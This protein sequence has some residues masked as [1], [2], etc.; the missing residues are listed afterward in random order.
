MKALTK[1]SSTKLDFNE[2]TKI[3]LKD[4]DDNKADNI[5]NIDLR[6][7]SDLCQTMIIASGTSSRHASSLA[8]NLVFMLKHL[9]NRPEFAVEGLDSGQWVVIDLYNIVIHIFVPEVRGFYDLEGLW[10]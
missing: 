5:I 8:E 3:I 9:E 7:K 6:K 10:G 2:L 1:K 4:L